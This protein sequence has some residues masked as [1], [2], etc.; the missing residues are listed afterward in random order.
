MQMADG[1]EFILSL[2]GELDEG[3]TKANVQKALENV[4]K[5]V[6]LKSNSKAVKN[7]ITV[8]DKEQLEKDGI[9]YL[10]SAKDIESQLSQMFKGIGT[11]FEVNKTFADDGSI[12]KFVAKIYEGT[13]A[14]QT[15]NFE[16]AKFSDNTIGFRQVG[17]SAKSGKISTVIQNEIESLK[18]QNEQ[19]DLQDILLTRLYN[20]KQ[21]LNDGSI[22]SDSLKFGKLN[23]DIRLLENQINSIDFSKISSEGENHLNKV[24]KATFEAVEAEHKLHNV[25]MDQKTGVFNIPVLEKEGISF[26]DNTVGVVNRVKQELEDKGYL[27]KMSILSRDS[28]GGVTA[29]AA[30]IKNASGVVDTLYY[31]LVRLNDGTKTFD[32]FM[33]S[34]GKQ[35]DNTSREYAKALEKQTKDLAKA[36][37][38]LNDLM[39]KF[40]TGNGNKVLTGDERVNDILNKLTEAESIVNRLNSN[41]GYNTP[42]QID[43]VKNLI[44]EIEKEANEYVNLENKQK[45]ATSEYERQTKAV[46]DLE[47]R[48]QSLKDKA[49]IGNNALKDSFNVEETKKGLEEVTAL[50]NQLKANRGTNKVLD[51]SEFDAVDNKLKE[52]GQDISVFKDI[53]SLINKDKASTEAQLNALSSV[54]NK[55]LSI[56]SKMLDGN[57]ITTPSY[58]TDISNQ[59]AGVLNYIE[60]LRTKAGS[61]TEEESRKLSTMV[62]TLQREGDEYA[63]I[64]AAQQKTDANLQN[65]KK[66]LDSIW[67]QL[68]NIFKTT[69]SMDATKP[70]IDKGGAEKVLDIYEKLT[71][72]VY[73]LRQDNTS[74]EIISVSKLQEASNLLAQ[75]NSQINVSRQ[76]DVFFKDYGAQNERLQTFIASLKNTG[77]YTGELKK[78]VDAL[79]QSFNNVSTPKELEVFKGQLDTLS[80]RAKRAGLDMKTSFATEELQQKIRLL[81]SQVVAYMN[82]NTKAVA[83]FK[84]QFD[85]LKTSITNITD[86]NALVK[87]QN[88]FKILQ[89]NISNAGK[90]G[91]TFGERMAAAAKKFLMWTGMTNVVMYLVRSIKQMI[92]HTKELDSA[93]TFLKRVTDETDTT[94]KNMF[95]NAIKKA[96]ELN[97]SVKDLI[98]STAEFAK[99]GFDAQQAEQLAE[100][101]TVYARVGQ[102]DMTDATESIVSTLSGFK[103]LDVNDVWKIVDE[104]DNVGKIVA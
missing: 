52:I 41:A 89:Q 70:I 56:Q 83:Q 25:M 16:A 97:S 34:Y 71:Q 44:K 24:V 42:D 54:E 28:S 103:D 84:A 20:A 7:T 55:I 15:L 64:D 67:I 102:L 38:D 74:G 85:A 82:Q 58:I 77:L 30:E 65:Q 32:G 100:A 63:R 19:L 47:S 91:L 90:A 13:T 45:Q 14:I 51:Q 72:Y 40:L 39:T 22:S 80:E 79:A 78:D 1:N 99:L 104:F 3:K 27:P 59:V 2:I 75:L 17:G 68:E 49:F 23:E 62:A 36:K 61:V 4:S 21:M 81:S 92:T 57:K 87:A 18:S 29:F 88:E 6:S 101:T 9:A 53:E 60:T 69:I 12:S 93:M 26:Y 98:N 50:I 76:D 11:S 43:G 31:D 37:T 8:F 94:Y 35:I 95:D 10:K 66:T 5:N 48:L 96:K 86:N 46:G 33:S 73:Q